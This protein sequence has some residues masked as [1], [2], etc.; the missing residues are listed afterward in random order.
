M[1]LQETQ[2][3]QWFRI[4]NISRIILSQ[5]IK[6]LNLHEYAF[7]RVMKR[8]IL[9][10]ILSMSLT[11]TGCDFFRMVAGRPSSKDIGQKRVEIMKA[12]E[13][14]LQARL[15]SIAKVEAEAKKAVQDSIDAL[16]YIAENK[17][18]LHNV[19]RL[20]GLAKDELTDTASGTRYRV[21]LGSFRDRGNAEKLVAKVGEAGDFGAHLI[22]L[23]S[24]MIAVAACPSDR[25]QN[26]VWG[27]KELKTHPVCPADAWILNC[28]TND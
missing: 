11:V 20:G 6:S 12:E 13:A 5:T 14:A 10:L 2:L 28:D 24:G 9:L 26:V 21:M 3:K 7:L 4:T 1:S 23:R 16:E 17:I 27:L 22:V 15:D 19:A 8:S 18:T 25:I